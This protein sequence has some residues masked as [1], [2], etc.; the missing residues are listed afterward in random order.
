MRYFDIKCVILDRKYQIFCGGHTN[1]SSTITKHFT[2]RINGILLILCPLCFSF[3]PYNFFF[4]GFIACICSFK[5]CFSLFLNSYS[6]SAVVFV[7]LRILLSE[8]YV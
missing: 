1:Q 4:L 5:I 7:F 2:E 3:N 8:M 6:A